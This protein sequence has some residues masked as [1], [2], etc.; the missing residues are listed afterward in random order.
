VAKARRKTSSHLRVPQKLS[1]AAYGGD[2]AG[3]V[4]RAAVIGAGRLNPAIGVKEQPLRGLAVAHRPVERV[5]NS[6][7]SMR[8]PIA[9]ILRW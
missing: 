3:L 7:V 6:S 1:L 2:Q 8:G 9:Q 5:K 4:E